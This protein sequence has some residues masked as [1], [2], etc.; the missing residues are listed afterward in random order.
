MN[1]RREYF[2]ELRAPPMGFIQRLEFVAR[3]VNRLWLTDVVD[4]TD[5]EMPYMVASTD[6]VDALRLDPDV[7]GAWENI[8]VPHHGVLPHG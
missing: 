6:D 4:M 2:I 5:S 1:Q 7:V 3:I 8:D